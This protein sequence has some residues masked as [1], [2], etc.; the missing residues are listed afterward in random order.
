MLNGE[1]DL[2]AS[3]HERVCEVN[4]LHTTDRSAMS[5]DRVDWSV[6]FVE[7][8]GALLRRFIASANRTI[9]QRPRVERETG[10]SR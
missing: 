4:G 8:V 9:L 1:N 2:R 6:R 7:M 3:E 10:E 5:W